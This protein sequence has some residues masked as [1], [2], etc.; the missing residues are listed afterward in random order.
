MPKKFFRVIWITAV[1]VAA[2]LSCNLATNIGKQ[3]NQIKETAQ[4]VGT[5]VESGRNLISTAQSVVTQVEGSGLVKTVENVATEQGPSLMK[6]ARAFATDQGPS[7]QQTVQAFATDQGPGLKSTVQAF[8]TQQAPTLLKTAYAMATNVSSSQ[9]QTPAD[10]PLV[11]GEKDNFFTSDA[12]ISYQTAT[13]YQTVLDF[14]TQ[15]MLQN[16][17][18]AV[19]QGTVK[20][21][22]GAVLNYEKSDRR[23]TVTISANPLDQKTLVLIAITKK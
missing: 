14:Y 7:L 19:E 2:S 20:S 6:T 1:L 9:G 8:S 22:Q 21:D 10:I 18:T 15:E 17:W 23:V 12:L 3:A 5:S 16:G 4:S 13:D 11:E